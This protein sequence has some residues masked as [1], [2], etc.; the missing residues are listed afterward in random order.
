MNILDPKFRYVNS[1][2]T[3]LRKTF[4]KV[5]REMHTAQSVL[6]HAATKPN[7]VSL[8]QLRKSGV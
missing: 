7:V 6:G 1:Y 2:S 4:A 8:D 5:R 3:D